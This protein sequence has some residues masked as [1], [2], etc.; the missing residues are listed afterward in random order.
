MRENKSRYEDS[1][2]LLTCNDRLKEI[3]V[4]KKK[5]QLIKKF[6]IKIK[7][8]YPT[9]DNLSL[10]SKKVLINKLMG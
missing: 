8:K 10:L 2:L 3:L 4:Q 9:I 6:Y 5:P 7:I 1:N